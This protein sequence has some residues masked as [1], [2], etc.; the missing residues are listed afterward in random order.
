MAEK[1]IAAQRLDVLFMRIR[2]SLRNTL[3]AFQSKE[4]RGSLSEVL[5]P[6]ED[7]INL[8]VSYLLEKGLTQEEVQQFR[9]EYEQCWYEGGQLQLLMRNPPASPDHQSLSD[10][11]DDPWMAGFVQMQAERCA[12]H[13]KE[14]ACQRE[15]AIDALSSLL[16][17]VDDLAYIVKAVEKKSPSGKG[18]EIVRAKMSWQKAAAYLED[19]RANGKPFESQAAYAEQLQCSP[20]T[21]NKAI[22]ETSSLQEWAKRPISSTSWTR[23]IDGAIFDKTPQTRET[24]P[25]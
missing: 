16:K 1:T 8:T 18:P 21:V 14:T 25:Q 23:N 7:I 24:D 4:F 2:K 22:A 13:R 3:D 19:L 17:H 9:V 20:S 12:D 5:I 10:D 15:I 11:P 6:P